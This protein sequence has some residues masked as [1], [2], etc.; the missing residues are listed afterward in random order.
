MASSVRGREEEREEKEER[1]KR[2][3]DHGE[4]DSCGYGVLLSPLSDG[5]GC[6]A[7]ESRRV[8]QG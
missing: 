2:E 5:L 6:E 7:R 8:H 3:R 4:F 1:K